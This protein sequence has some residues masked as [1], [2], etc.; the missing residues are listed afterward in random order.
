MTPRSQRDRPPARVR[1]RA[2]ARS[3]EV[4][5]PLVIGPTRGCH[6]PLIARGSLLTST[7]RGWTG[8]PH[9]PLR[10]LLT[11]QYT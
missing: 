2:H 4:C 9:A 5:P 3:P 11:I 6:V 8:Q 10:R 1:Q 7:L